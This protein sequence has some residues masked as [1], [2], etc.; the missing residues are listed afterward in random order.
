MKK[1][2]PFVRQMTI[3]EIFDRNTDSVLQPFLHEMGMNISREIEWQACK[4]RTFDGDT[5]LDFRVVGY[6]RT[7]PVCLCTKPAVVV[8]IAVS[9]FLLCAGTPTKFGLIAIF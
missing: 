4:H 9:K 7:D 1:A 2:V 6:E 5:V 8:V 3:E